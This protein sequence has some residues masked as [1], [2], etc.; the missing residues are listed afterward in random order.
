MKVG[1]FI[2]GQHPIESSYE[3]ARRATQAGFDSL[4]MPDH[5]LGSGSSIVSR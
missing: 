3:G 2:W 4:W 1:S 5:L